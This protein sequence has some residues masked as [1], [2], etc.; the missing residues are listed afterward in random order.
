MMFYQTKQNNM[1]HIIANT[2]KYS[3]I[4]EEIERFIEIKKKKPTIFKGTVE[5]IDLSNNIITANLQIYNRLNLS[6]GSLILIREDGPLSINIRATIKD[7]Y[8]SNIKLEIKTNP[9]QFENKKIIIDTDKTNVI[10]ERLRNIIENIKKGKISSD[11]VRILDFIIGINKPR[12]SKKEVSFISKELNEAQKDGIINSIKAEDL[13]LIIGPPG[14][15]KTYVIEELIRQ[16]IKIDQ[17]ILITAWTNL[18][19]DNIIKRLS[20][21][22]TKNI[23]RIGPINEIDL[24]VKKFSIF[25]KMKEHEDWKEVERHNKIISELYELIPRKKDELNSVQ[26]NISHNKNITKIFEMELEK[27]ITE[28]QKY[29]KLISI[30][31]NKRPPVNL[32]FIND[33]LFLINKKSE[34]YLSLSKNIL[35]MN[36]LQLQIPKAEHIQQLKNITRSMKFSILGKKVFSFFSKTNNKELEKLKKD[37]ERNRKSIDEFSKL[38]RKYNN[39]NKICNDEFNRIYFNGNGSPDKDALNFE[40][41]A[42]KLLEDNYLPIFKEQ[43]ITNMTRRTSEVNQEVYMIC[44]DSIEKKIDLLAVKIRG[45]NADRDIQINHEEDLN[46]QYLNLQ[47]S[48]DIYEKNIDMLKKTIMSDIINKADLIAATAISSCHNFLDDT[49]FDVMIMD[50]A[51]QVASFM[52]LLPLLKC[53]KFIL[54]G[55]NRQLQPIE[56]EDISKEMNL[57]IFNRLFEMYPEASTLLTI[58]YRMHKTIAQIASE[59][60]YDGKLITSENIAERILSLKMSEHQF[61]NPKMPVIF[62]DT[63]NVEYYEDEVGSSCSNQKEAEYVAYIASLF[64]KSRIKTKDIGIV[65]PYVKQKHLIEEFLKDIKINDIDVDTVHKFQGREKDIIIMSFARSKKYSFT[66]DKLK[67]IENEYLV[68]VALTRAKKKL[69]LVGNYLTLCRSKLLNSVIG[70]IGSKNRIIL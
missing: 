20:K 34:N 29:D 59:I 19:V 65:T 7:F 54:V 42:Y 55:D 26:E 40:F 5:S 14:T 49:N 39:L 46:N 61:L 43:E 30:P 3:K 47:F 35:Q 18:A 24:E 69:I 37:Y 21:K 68:N 28:K 64:I 11:N 25:E 22:E 66:Q 41:M 53:K 31:I 1:E 60:F 67:F 48:L 62:I 4:I 38:Q 70:K 13:H 10:L 57:S 27:H 16:F 17:K 12:Y 50:E 63:S 2:E 56:E 23:V 36:E 6:R 8:N 45:L 52:S 9:S 58:Q 51:S 44:I 33:E 32:S 15:G